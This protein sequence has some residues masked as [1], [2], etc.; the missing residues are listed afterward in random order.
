MGSFKLKK[1]LDLPVA[2]KPAQEIT[3]GRDIRTAAVIAADYIGLKPRLLVQEGET[4]GIGTPLFFHKD[5]PEVMITSPAAGR[6][7]AVNRGARRV[8]ISV[9]IDVD[10]GAQPP[11]DFSQTGD[12]TTQ[13]GLV[14]RLCASGLWT[15]FR[16]RPYSKVPEPESRPAAIFVT[17]MDSEPLS[18]DP[19]VV[20]ADAGSAFETG[21][22]A[23]ATLTSGTTYLCHET[24]AAMPGAGIAGVELADF[25]GPHPAGLA[26]TH[27]HFLQP[28]TSA[29][30]VWTIGYQDVIAIGRLLETGHYDPRRVIALSGPLCTNPRLVRTVA[31]ASL[32][33]LAE[34][35]YDASVP[36]RLISGSILSGRLGEGPSA[37]LGRYA[38]QI[39]LIEEDHKQIPMGWIR[40][41]PGKY[42]VQPVLGSAFAKKV[43]NLTSNLNGGRRAM[44]PIGTFEEIMPQDYLPTQ[45]LR[46]LLVMDTDQAQALGALELDEEDLGLVGFACPAKYEYGMALRD[47]LT[48]IEKE[49]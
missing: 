31:G 9:E 28:P 38:R 21:L 47:C 6:V 8:L 48:K 1:G 24:G 45:L 16:T 41:M 10:E 30:M 46:A 49:G 40:P 26:G 25:S 7:R 2:G 4:V 44:V 11:Q 29:E 43:Y 15:S 42:A 12:I 39:T 33:E 35:E 17:A 5:S 36:V 18:G 19:A 13:E 27:I 23:V 20:I 37:Y 14:E 34:G 3:D 22:A 32:T